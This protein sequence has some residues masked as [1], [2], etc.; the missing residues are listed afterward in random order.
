MISFSISQPIKIIIA[1]IFLSMVFVIGPNTVIE[2][3]E[4]IQEQETKIAKIVD[5]KQLACMTKNIFYHFKFLQTP[6]KFLYNY[7]HK[8]QMPQTKKLILS[9]YKRK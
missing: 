6:I 4:P 7:P 1:F 8:L 5:P 9:I 3:D 2:T